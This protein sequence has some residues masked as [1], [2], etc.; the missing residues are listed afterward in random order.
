[1]ALARKYGKFPWSGKLGAFTVRI[2]CYT[3]VRF[4]FVRLESRRDLGRWKIQA[5][6]SAEGNGRRLHA[7]LAPLWRDHL[8]RRAAPCWTSFSCRRRRPSG[9]LGRGQLGQPVLW[10]QLAAPQSRGSLLVG[11]LPRGS[12]PL[13]RSGTHRADL[14]EPGGQDVSGCFQSCWGRICCWS[15]TSG[16]SRRFLQQ[17]AQL[18]QGDSSC[19]QETKHL[20]TSLL[21]S[22]RWRQR[23]Q[24]GALLGFRKSWIE[25]T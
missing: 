17:G 23:V 4:D 6:Q 19:C 9:L 1:M 2:L 20:E 22:T 14:G 11:Q 15:R 13:P 5:A 10:V 8:L 18:E 12:A 24:E 7:S 16:R 3:Y 21:G 25:G